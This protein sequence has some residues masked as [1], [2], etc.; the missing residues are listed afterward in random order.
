MFGH[1]FL[2]DS[3]TDVSIEI[4]TNSD[5]VFPSLVAQDRDVTYR[6]DSRSQSIRGYTWLTAVTRC[7][8]VF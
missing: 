5:K 4:V 3:N 8:A 2:I 1:S 7:T 6:H